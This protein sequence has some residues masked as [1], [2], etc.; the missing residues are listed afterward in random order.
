M[1]NEGKLFGLGSKAKIKPL[2]LLDTYG[3]LGFASSGVADGKKVEACGFSV[4]TGTSAVPDVT[5]NQSANVNLINAADVPANMRCYLTRL[6]IDV[7]GNAAWSGGNYMLVQD[8][9]NAPLVY[10]PAK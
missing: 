7:R 9:N 8:S 6:D 5:F 2:G 10:L 4:C 3:L 1:P